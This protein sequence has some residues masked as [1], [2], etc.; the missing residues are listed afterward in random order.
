MFPSIPEPEDNDLE[1]AG[2]T[3]AHDSNSDS[4]PPYGDFC[5]R[6]G[7]AETSAPSRPLPA[8]RRPAPPNAGA[9]PRPPRPFI[10]EF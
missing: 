9:S 10:S 8:W 5:D 4:R 6:P 3:L 7:P 1:A 2:D